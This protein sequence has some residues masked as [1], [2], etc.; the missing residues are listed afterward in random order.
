MSDPAVEQLTEGLDGLS[1]KPKVEEVAVP[2]KVK[3][4]DDDGY[5]SANSE[6]VVSTASKKSEEEEEEKE[7]EPL[8]FI[9]EKSG[10]EIVHLTYDSRGPIPIDGWGSPGFKHQHWSHFCRATDANMGAG[11]SFRAQLSDWLLITRS[12]KSCKS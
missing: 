7:L 5:N 9:D 1:V 4:E 6:E 10:L 8:S 2:V 11:C 3:A 12:W